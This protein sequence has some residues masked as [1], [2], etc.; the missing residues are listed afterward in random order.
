MFCASRLRPLLVCVASS[1][2]GSGNHRQPT[3]VQPP[4]KPTLTIAPHFSRF[5]VSHF[6]FV[7]ISLL[8]P[9][10]SIPPSIFS[11]H[12]LVSAVVECKQEEIFQAAAHD[13]S[14][15][16][17]HLKPRAISILY[18]ISMDCDFLFDR[19]RTILMILQVLQV[20]LC[21]KRAQIAN[22]SISRG[23]IFCQLQ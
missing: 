16:P 4:Y 10:T 5:V 6:L 17:K 20:W 12:P 18:V 8:G 21:R 2:E 13:R 3:L 19:F 23:I 7:I 9:T 22:K 11:I 15:K 1:A 14:I